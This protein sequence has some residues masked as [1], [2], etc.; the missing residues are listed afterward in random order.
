[1]NH[2]V[3]RD[4]LPIDGGDLAPSQ[5]YRSPFR[6]RQGSAESGYSWDSYTGSKGSGTWKGVDNIESRESRGHP[7]QLLGRIPWNIGGSFVHTRMHVN[8]FGDYAS[9]SKTGTLRRAWK[10]VLAPSGSFVNRC[11][12][13][14]ESYDS[15]RNVV[16]VRAPLGS[17]GTLDAA[18]A[19]AISRCSP[20]NPLVDL[21]TSAAE[22]LREGLPQL[23]G[24]AGNV[25]GEYLNVMFGYVPLYGDV[26]D[27][28]ST[29]RKHDE[30]LRQY[31]RD[32]G[33][34]IRRR[35]SFP[36]EYT[37]SHS[38]EGGS[39]PGLYGLELSGTLVQGG[40]RHITTAVETK[41]W[42]S[43]AFTYYLPQSGWRRSVA[44]L[45]HLYGVKPG[46]DTLYDLTPYS[47][48]ADY[49]TNTGDV[50]QNINAF[51]SDGLVMPYGYV[52]R[53][54]TITYH[55]LWTGNLLVGNNW[56]PHSIGGEI[57]YKVQQRRQANP[58]GFGLSPGSL[59]TRQKSILVAL[60]ISL[61]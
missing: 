16:T 50:M 21:S 20:T 37:S 13:V 2:P 26:K 22:L 56:T 6:I 58:F 14:S 52:M 45:D 29:A 7:S 10:G 11:A 61:L 55:E 59:T 17:V 3:G 60:G 32:S 9:L 31:E 35:Y 40:T 36:V 24:R 46:I 28:I 48:L 43:G 44:E 1:M 33:R 12:R 8:K 57:V 42:F 30:L 27:V 49:F 41:T 18:G 19:T 54:Q 15:A 39:V 47:W 5:Y 23:P 51:T 53:E 25:G 34:W 38:V 4:F